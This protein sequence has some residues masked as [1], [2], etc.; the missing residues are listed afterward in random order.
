MEIRLSPVVVNVSQVGT[1]PK[2][3]P[4][5]FRL[6]AFSANVVVF[7]EYVVGHVAPITNRPVW[8]VVLE[9]LSY[10]TTTYWVS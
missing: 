6:I 5:L 3:L 7:I 2:E 8:H 9:E 1:L 4:S 10:R